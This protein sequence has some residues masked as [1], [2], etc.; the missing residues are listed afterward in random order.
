[1]RNAQV[2]SKIHTIIGLSVV[3]E[4]KGEGGKRDRGGRKERVW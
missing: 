3:E 1:M 4:G 2:N